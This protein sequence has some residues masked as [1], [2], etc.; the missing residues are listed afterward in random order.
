MKMHRRIVQVLLSA[1]LTLLALGAHAEYLLMAR[2]TQGFPE[3]M[4]A[5]QTSLKEHG[6]TISRVQ[7]VDIG[8]TSSGFE[9]DK[10]RIVFFGKTDEQRALVDKYPHLIPY[11]PLKMTLFAEDNETVVVTEDYTRLIELA[12]DEEL[13]NQFMRWRNDVL[14]ILD[15]LRHIE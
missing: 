11:L 6:Y 3:T 10:Y 5:L 13:A 12:T 4:L 15:E 7:R 1:A 8:L 9:T 2:S 14:S